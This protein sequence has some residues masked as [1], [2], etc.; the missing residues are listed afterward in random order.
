VTPLPGRVGPAPRPGTGSQCT[1]LGYLQ[2]LATERATAL[3]FHEE[4]A[5]VPQGTGNGSSR[6]IRGRHETSKPRQLRNLV[7]SHGPRFASFS[8]IGLAVLLLGLAFQALLVRFGAGAYGSYLGQIVFSVELSFALN[9]RFTWPSRNTSLW[10]SCWK[11]NVQKLLLTVPNVALYALL[12]HA[13]LGWLPANLA[14]TAVLTGANY[15]TG[16][17]WSF[18]ERGAR[19]LDR[20]PAAVAGP[21]VRAELPDGPLPV[22]SVIIPCK[23]NQSTIRAT[24]DALLAQDYPGL[25]EVIL[26]GDVNDSTWTAL[27][28]IRDPR[29]VLLEQEATPGKR[30]PNV[31]RDTGIRHATGDILALVD[32]DIVMEPD[33]LS[34]A[35][36]ML[37]AQGGDLVAGGMRSIHD[38]FW[39]RF[40]DRNVLAAKTPRLPEPY[41]VTAENFGRHGYKPP[42]TANAVFTRALYESCPLDVAWAYGYE[43]YEWFWRVV[44]AGHPVLFSDAIT[45]AHHHRRSFRRLV[46]EYRQSARGC[47]Q[48]IRRHPDSALARKR[49][50]QGLLLP[51]AAV[52]TAA[53]AIM[54]GLAGYGETVGVLL[55]LSLT[56]LAAR[57]VA[58][59]RSLEGL[60]Y[61]PATL[62]LG[63]IYAM[64]IAG[65]LTR[66]KLRAEATS[67]RA[68]APPPV[69]ARLRRI[70]WPLAL[71]LAVQAAF[72]LSL[73]WSNTAFA[74]EANYL[75]QGHLEWAHWLHGAPLPAA[76]LRDSGIPQIYPP[77]GALASDIG[78]L[79]GARILSMC[80]MLTATALLYF[81]AMRLFG[82]GA[83]TIAAA[84]WAFS[85]PVLR[86]AF[87]TYDPLA[88][89]LVILATWLAVQAGFRPRRGEVVGLSAI[90]LA[91]A[92]G[93]AFSF[94]IMIPAVIAVAFFIW[95]PQMGTRNA[96]WCT[97]WLAGTSVVLT[98]ALLTVTDSW[99]YAIGSTITRSGGSGLGAGLSS[100]LR[101]AWSWDGLIFAIAAA[102]AVAAF[103]LE[104]SWA[105]K[106]LVLSL[107]AAGVLVPAYQAHLGVG[108]SLDKHMSAGAGL[109]AIAAGYAFSRISL[110]RW[111]PAVAAV[112]AVA[113]LSFP[114]V[115]GL[116]YARSTFHSWPNTASLVSFL[117]AQPQRYSGA[118]DLVAGQSQAAYWAVRFYLPWLPVTEG[119]AAVDITKGAYPLVV[120]A[121]D[122]SLNSVALPRDAAAGSSAVVGEVLKLAAGNQGEYPLAEA[123]EHSQKY[124]IVTSIPYF[125]TVST[126]NS[127]LFVVWQL[128]HP[129]AEPRPRLEKRRETLR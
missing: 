95:Q 117:R 68:D 104:Q 66:N 28:D 106:L 129:A 116:W 114:A 61:T 63:W 111:K 25:A 84:L 35:I 88:C 124:R 48:F 54:A 69:L 83:A 43:D 2:Q 32:S 9:R 7:T 125:T 19:R 29:L 71:I 123:L 109:M 40:V 22:A 38:T 70:H 36:A 113:L 1:E 21:D 39:G 79:A 101:S 14:V 31:K 41:H 100:V 56:W 103:A 97:G 59:S 16:D 110:P 118:P 127:G 98:V 90:T 49:R 72:S 24:V 46:L 10:S 27:R 62:A 15:V 120:L 64:T 53:A 6:A 128:V 119:S 65:G 121:L 99:T 12:V 3:A 57:E 86:L 77:I 85:E 37:L 26:V 11:F 78:G 82:R 44:K 50:W 47:V 93:T 107:A 75:T 30:D 17:R 20:S 45:A 23:G 105:R 13:G 81:I 96:T 112:A 76:A 92:S 126:D 33:W 55:V 5:M 91:L 89:L 94:A 74:D 52:T 18:A 8:V 122:A 102:G 115:T 4:P 51:P 87:A 108:W 80:F 58:Q 60:A 42:V 67:P 34:K 73:V